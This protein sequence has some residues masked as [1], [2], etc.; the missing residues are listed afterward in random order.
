MTMS[1]IAVLTVK[2]ATV[3][4]E[5]DQGDTDARPKPEPNNKRISDIAAE[6]TAPARMA[7]QATAEVVASLEPL[8]F[9]EVL[10]KVVAVCISFL[11]I[12]YLTHE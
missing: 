8:T 3:T 2:V 10:L 6:V 12:D 7:G 4:P 11:S 1:H 9:A 5:F